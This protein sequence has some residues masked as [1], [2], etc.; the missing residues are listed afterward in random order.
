MAT[1]LQGHIQ[2]LDHG[3]LWLWLDTKN[4]AWRWLSLID[5][6]RLPGIQDDGHQVE[7]EILVNGKRCRRDSMLSRPTPY[8]R[9]CPSWIMTS[10]SF[11]IIARCWSTTVNQDVGHRKHQH[12][13]LPPHLRPCRTGLYV[14]WC[15]LPVSMAATVGQC[16]DRVFRARNCAFK[17]PRFFRKT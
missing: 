8:F 14:I 4:T 2:L 6:S 13:R 1:R 15:P 5:D 17:K 7:V 3:R 11:D 12:Q 10:T 16:R 9:S